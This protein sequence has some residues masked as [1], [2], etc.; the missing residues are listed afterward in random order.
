MSEVLSTQAASSKC[1]QPVSHKRQ[2]QRALLL[3]TMEAENPSTTHI[4]LL[5]RVLVSLLKLSMHSSFNKN[6]L[7][8]WPQQCLR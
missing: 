3:P 2:S 6:E 1:Q 5:D 4:L 8:G 7:N